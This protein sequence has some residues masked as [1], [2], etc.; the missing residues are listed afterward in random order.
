MDNQCVDSNI[1]HI[2]DYPDEFSLELEACFLQYENPGLI[3]ETT[4]APE[5]TEST[6]PG[7]GSDTTLGSSSVLP[8]LLTVMVLVAIYTI[9]Q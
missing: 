9:C 7:E 5:T 4:S 6:T 1:E 2:I 8:N 3:F